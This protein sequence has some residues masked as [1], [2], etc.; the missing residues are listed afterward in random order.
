MFFPRSY[1]QIE[2]V[3]ES[4]FDNDSYQNSHQV[5]D[6][7]ILVVDDEPALR[8]LAK[9]ILSQEG[10]NVYCAN[11]GSHAMDVMETTKIDLILSDVIM[12]IMDGYQLVDQ[13]R[14]KYSNVKI[15]LTSGFTDRR[16]RAGDDEKRDQK[17]LFKPYNSQDLIH[18]VNEI[19]N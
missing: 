8:K 15:I 10:F 12:P 1:E 3:E 6:I 7:N 17:L 14:E 18:R 16:N 5:K 11:N 19:L 2:S 9:E 4:D 13:V